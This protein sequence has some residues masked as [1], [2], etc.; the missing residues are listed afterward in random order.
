M[1]YIQNSLMDLLLAGINEEHTNLTIDKSL[2][3]EQLYE[4]ARSHQI[5]TLIY[6]VLAKYSKEYS[7][8]ETFMEMAR[9]E[10]LLDIALQDAHA[11]QM[12]EVLK[13]FHLH[14]IPVI[15]LKGL[16]LRDYYPDPALRLMGDGDILVKKEMLEASKS[17]FLSLGYVPHKANLRHIG[18]SYGTFPEIELH[19]LLS[20]YEIDAIT[21]TFSD[22]VWEHALTSTFLNIPVLRL[23]LYDQIIHLLLHASQHMNSGGFG[24]RQLCDLVLF[25][26]VHREEINWETLLDLTSCYHIHRFSQALL[27]VCKKLFHLNLPLPHVQGLDENYIDMFIDDIFDAGVYG[28]KTPARASSSRMIRYMDT[29]NTQ[30]KLFRVRYGFFFLF[31]SVR[32]MK[33]NYHYLRKCPFLLPISWVHRMARN[34]NKLVSFQVD[35]SVKQK[36]EKRFQL[37]LW[38][39]LR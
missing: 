38:L 25:L 16:V 2:P 3:I 34:L 18:F 37:L 20:D 9:K 10:F 39:Q 22:H 11:T 32:I 17:L 15:I 4:E 21:P 14:Q 36:N 23:S 13:A 35:S 31:P 19:T 27:L 7:F 24:L 5:H 1:N 26:Q 6:P 30:G 8:D 29:K 28:R 12:S 33:K